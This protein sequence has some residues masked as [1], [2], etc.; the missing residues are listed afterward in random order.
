MEQFLASQMDITYILSL[1]PSVVLPNRPVVSYSED[2]MEIPDFS[3]E[4]E[5]S[6][7]SQQ[8]EPNEMSKQEEKKI[9]HN[10]YMALIKY[11]HKKR[12]GIIEKVTAEVTE[13][14]VLNAVH[15]SNPRRSKVF[16][17]VF[18]ITVLFILSQ[19]Y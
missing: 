10:A 13:E 12:L 3:D 9:S 16:V 15:S 6:F 2:I 7:P 19:N 11:L 1:Y 17:K 8:I 18:M 14:V 5:S 4:T